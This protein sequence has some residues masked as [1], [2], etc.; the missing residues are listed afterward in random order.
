MLRDFR[1]GDQVAVRTL[2]LAG[3][4][5]RG[6]V[7]DP[8]H[9]ADLDDIAATYGHGRTV[10][11]E[12]AGRIVATGTVVPRGDGDAEI[13]RMSVATDRRREGLGEQI[14]GALTATAWAWGCRRVVLETTSTWT[15]AIAFY[16]RC[17]F[18]I[19]HEADGDFG[20]DTWF[21]RE[22]PSR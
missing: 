5:E 13:V 4:E 21:A 22:M 19:T 1:P 14:V 7:L 10:V 16:R 15:D 6:G 2:I 17:G 18:V 20:R 3:L 11:V 9:N 8:R 12:H